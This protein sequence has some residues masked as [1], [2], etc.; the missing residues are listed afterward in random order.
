MTQSTELWVNRQRLR[1]TR[2]VRSALPPLTEG[3]VRVAIDRFGLTANNVSYAVAGDSIGYWGYFPAEGDWGKVPVWGCGNVVESNCTDIPVGN[4]LF[5][6]FPMA[7]HAVLRPGKIRDDQFVDISAHRAELPA[8]Y[9]AYRRT[10]G[11]PGF[12]RELEIE[13]CLL[14]PLFVTSW[15]IYD[16]LLDNDFFGAT[17][18]LIGSVSS[19]TGFGLA[20]MLH[21][22][23]N[24]NQRVIGLT[25]AANL[26]FVDRLACCDEIVVYGDEAKLDAGAPTAYVDMS[27][28]ARLTRTLHELLG[29]NMRV[30][31]MVG[32]T[33][34]EQRGRNAALPGPKPTFFFAPAQIGKRDSEWGPGIAM[35]KAMTASVE[36]ARKLREE[37]TVE[38]TRDVRGLA[39][40]WVDLLDNKVSPSRGSMVSLSP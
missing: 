34:W 17:Q 12:L 20:E 32:A 38:W 36:V 4:R 31:T 27:G 37:M 30:S 39:E 8:L 28:N 3:E 33:H 11:E 1:D 19:K 21:A 35:T 26:P 16:Y 6:F 9:N 40:L 25:S 2:I 13:R 23:A 10:G 29:E 15:L 24:V 14:F 22:D 7:S 18:V 5:G